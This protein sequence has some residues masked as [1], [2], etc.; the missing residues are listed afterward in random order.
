MLQYSA[1][2]CCTVRSG[3]AF[4]VFFRQTS[5]GLFISSTNEKEKI[6]VFIVKNPINDAVFAQFSEHLSP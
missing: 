1:K 5:I 3:H 6:P 2:T 4:L